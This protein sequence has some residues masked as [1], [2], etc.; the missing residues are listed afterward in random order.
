MSSDSI[1]DPENVKHLRTE[2]HSKQEMI[3]KYRQDLLHQL[4][5]YIIYVLF[6]LEIVDV[7][8]HIHTKEDQIP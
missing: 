2:L 4:R 1:T 3:N 6:V 8:L 5:Y 7:H